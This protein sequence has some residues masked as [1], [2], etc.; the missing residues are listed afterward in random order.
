VIHAYREKGII[1]GQF[2]DARY[3]NFDLELKSGDRFL[4]YTDGIIETTNAVVKIFGWGRFKQIITSHANLPVGQF[5]DEL[6]QQ[7]SGG[8]GKD[9]QETLNDDLTLVIAEFEDS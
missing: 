7:V 5:A 4:L 9:A 6:I 2:K 8:S 3:H 1:L